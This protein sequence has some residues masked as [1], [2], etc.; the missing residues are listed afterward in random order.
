MDTQ[1]VVQSYL[2]KKHGAEICYVNFRDKD[3][4]GWHAHKETFKFVKM[5][6]G[7]LFKY[8]KSLHLQN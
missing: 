1:F 8:V 3:M 6:G 2:E 4:F 5:G 7:N